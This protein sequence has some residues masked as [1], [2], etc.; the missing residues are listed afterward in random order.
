MKPVKLHKH[1][2]EAVVQN[3]DAIFNQLR[4]A[5]KVIEYCLKSHRQWGSRDRAFVAS[6]TYDVVRWKRM[7]QFAVQCEERTDKSALWLMLGALRLW[8]N[9]PVAE[10]P[11]WK[12]L[13][14][15]SIF[16]R[17]ADAEKNPAVHHSIPDWLQQLGEIELK[18][19]WDAQMAALNQTAPL[20]IR[21]NTLKTTRAK[22]R[23]QLQQM[24][25][26]SEEVSNNTDAL[27]ISKRTNLFTTPMFNEGLLEVQDI[28]S[29]EVAPFLQVEP[30]MRVIDACA[31]AGGKTLHLAALLKNKGK[32]IAMDTEAWKLDEL[33]KRA[34]R[35]GVDCIET[36][37]LDDAKVIKRLE[38]SA[39]RLL[40]D[41]PCSGLGVLRRNPDAKWKLQPEFIDRIRETQQHILTEYSKMLK[42]GGKLVYATCSILPS[43]DENQVREF[44][45]SHAGFKL[46][47][48]HRTWP[49]DGVDGFYMARMVRLN[50]Q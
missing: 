14:A 21:V 43:E 40:L 38:N 5:D 32:I 2:F 22:I 10:W 33:K 48:E 19:K 3:C 16:K 12:N 41:V 42:P 28:A 25:I 13:D 46:E 23:Q 1:L 6:H 34:K 31:G 18:E 15:R 9:Q 29:Q 49:E 4:Y 44:L 35:A 36:R 37:V 30:G 47:A 39:D 27:I 7:L 24:Q 11:E 45:S 20:C 50:T 26:D 8:R 17:I